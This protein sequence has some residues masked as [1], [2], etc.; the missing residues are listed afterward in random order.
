M[1]KLGLIAERESKMLIRIS[2]TGVVLIA[3]LGLCGCGEYN[4]PSP[5]ERYTYVTQA[6]D[7]ISVDLLAGKLGMSVADRNPTHVTLKNAG[8]TVMIF[9]HSG[10][11]FYVNGKE[12]GP[13]G[14]TDTIGGTP[15]VA[16]S[17][18]D[19]IRPLLVS[20][21]AVSSTGYSRGYSRRLNGKVVIDAGHGGRDPGAISVRGFYEKTVNLK[22][23]HKVAARL[24]SRGLKVI[25]TR[26]DDR[27]IELE[28]RAAIANRNNADLFVSI[29][30]DSSFSRE[31]KGFTLYIAPDASSQSNMSARAI[32]KRMSR[33]GYDNNGIR[34]NNFRVL[35]KTRMPAV[36]VEMGY[37]SNHHEAGKIASDSFQNRIS[38][39]V[40]S[41]ICDVIEKI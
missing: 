40:A 21:S 35:M 20:G 28:E 18:A 22:V 23:A 19:K 31:L 37:I 16:E 17:L 12:K 29:H 1:Y 6:E 8:N 38:D 13:V 36:L 33:L 7:M 11:K 24:R 25:M 5:S 32:Q 26:D 3:T 14:E 4:Q 2:L 34:R 15:Y 41:G 10:G 9:T 27:F 39:A 30:A